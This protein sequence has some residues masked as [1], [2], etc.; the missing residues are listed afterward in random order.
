MA[1]L[2]RLRPLE[3]GQFLFDQ[4]R[5]GAFA[6]RLNAREQVAL[7]AFLVGDEPFE[8]GI[9]R[10][11]FGDQ[12]E[13]VERAARS[14]RQVGGDGRDDA[15]RR[16]CDHENGAPVQRQCRGCHRRRAASRRPTVQRCRRLVAD[17]DGTGI[18]QR[19]VDQEVGD[20][21]GRAVA[22]E[23]DGFDER[24]RPLAFVG[25]GEA[26]DGAAERRRWRRPR[27][28]RAARRAALPRRGTFRRRRSGHT[29]CAWSRT[30]TSHAG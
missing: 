16:A 26:G 13:Q 8:I 11:G 9:V 29:G 4:C 25:F 24:V 22:L 5:R 10:V 15:A 28:S 21:R 18:A 1:D 6:S 20:F 30:A 23:V 12:V 2:R 27:R 14:G 17:L 7:Q 19:F 3:R